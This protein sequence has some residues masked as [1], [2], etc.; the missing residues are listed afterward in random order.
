MIVVIE[1]AMFGKQHGLAG[2]RLRHD[3]GALTLAERRHQVDD[4]R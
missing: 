1:W 2:A 4:A 3:Q